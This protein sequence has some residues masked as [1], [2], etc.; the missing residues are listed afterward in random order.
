MTTTSPTARSGPS[1]RPR[2]RRRRPPTR[3]CASRSCASCATRSPTRAR[4][5]TSGSRPRRPRSTRSPARGSAEPADLG[6]DG[7][8]PGDGRRPRATTGDD[9]LALADDA[10]SAS[11]PAR[12][13]LLADRPTRRLDGHVRRAAAVA[14][15]R[16]AAGH[17]VDRARRR[18]RRGALSDPPFGDVDSA[19]G[20]G[21]GSPTRSP[22]TSDRPDFTSVWRPIPASSRGCAGW[23]RPSRLRRCRA[24]RR[25]PRWPDP[26]RALD[27]AATHRRRDGR[28]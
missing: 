18:R 22:A 1:R 24:A 4:R 23:R 13:R 15:H 12:R 9:P 19:L 25:W 7:A 8:V 2:R 28:Y 16:R 27:I 21:L 14:V 3:S 26:P 6:H 10:P 20:T 17:A 11:H 5:S